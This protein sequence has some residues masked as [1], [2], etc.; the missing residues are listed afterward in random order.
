[1]YVYH[2]AKVYVCKGC[3]NRIAVE[4]IDE[5]Y[6]HYLKGYLSDINP[7][8][9]LQQSDR[10]LAEKKALL[11]V[12]TTEHARLSKQVK[13]LMELFMEGKLT[14]ETF[15]PMINPVQ[16]QIVQLEK[17]MP[18]L[19][20]EISFREIQLASSDAVLTDAK[21]LYEQWHTM[22]FEEKRAIAETI[23][24]KIEI[25]KEDISITLA[26]I[27]VLS[28]KGGNVEHNLRGS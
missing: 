22:P 17:Q 14:K 1:M 28:Q 7:A 24:D 26:Y 20:A 27:P 21:E 10:E 12:T 4:D 16:E 6:Q 18:E 9:F 19:E 8:E 15:P 23:T 11:N 13:E 2:S 25:G 5:I 3:K